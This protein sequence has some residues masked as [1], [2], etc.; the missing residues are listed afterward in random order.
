MR[1]DDEDI[2]RKDSLDFRKLGL[3]GHAINTGDC[4]P[5]KQPPCRVPPYQREFI[6]QQLEELLA[7][8]RIKQS[9]SP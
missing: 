3:L 1:T 6:N 9:Q 4:K 5:V 8:G 2:F 7:T